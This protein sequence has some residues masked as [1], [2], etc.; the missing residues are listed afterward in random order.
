M[1]KTETSWSIK[2]T[3]EST[4]NG[5]LSML[6]NG[7][8][9]QVMERWMKKLAWRSIDHSTLFLN[10]QRT[11][12]SQFLTTEIWLS[13][14]QMVD[15]NKNGISINIPWQSDPDWTI[16]LSISRVLE[17]QT[18]CKFGALIPNGGRSSNINQSTLW[19]GKME[20]ALM[21]LV[22]KILKHNL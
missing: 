15:L 19:I 22:I 4:S 17:N 10:Y 20:N 2:N 1:L 8:V 5:T 11:D 9:N 21:Y 14:Y 13:R 12:T 6:M 16:N 3:E 7:R 18:T